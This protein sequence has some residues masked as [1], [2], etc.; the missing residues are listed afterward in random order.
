MLFTCLFLGV[1]VGRTPKNFTYK[2]DGKYTGIDTLINID[3]YYLQEDDIYGHPP[4]KMMFYR[5]GL[6]CTT[7]GDPIKYFQKEKLKYA[8]DWGR[9]YIVGDTIKLQVI[10]DRGLMDK[11]GCHSIQY[12]IISKTELVSLMYPT[13]SDPDRIKKE[14]M[15]K[16]T[17]QPL[18]SRLDSTN[19]L[20]K[21]KWFRK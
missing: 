9:Y 20:L 3:G 4:S 14:R 11:V 1:L 19:W 17:F 2:Y 12:L 15:K 5:D 6:F 10:Q 7:N 21:K 18:E 13:G 8:I 16:Y